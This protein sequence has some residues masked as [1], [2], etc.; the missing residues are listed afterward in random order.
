MNNA[1]RAQKNKMIH[2]NISVAIKRRRDNKSV[3]HAV[4]K[5]T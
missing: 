2:F 4:S 3:L 1:N 5:T